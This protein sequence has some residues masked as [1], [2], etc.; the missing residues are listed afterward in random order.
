MNASKKTPRPSFFE[1]VELRSQWRAYHERQDRENAEA[2]FRNAGVGLVTDL[3]LKFFPVLFRQKLNE[4]GRDW[5]RT[6]AASALREGGSFFR[7]EMR[8]DVD[9]V[10]GLQAALESKLARI[11][12]SLFF[13]SSG[14]HSIQEGVWDCF[15]Y[16]VLLP[17]RDP[18]TLGLESLPGVIGAPK[19]LRIA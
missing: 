17:D 14:L 12:A 19:V 18:E 8:V 15:L 10:N 3:D 7:A 13:E 16:F 1:L 2:V 4:F 9:S 6:I 5:E 11:G